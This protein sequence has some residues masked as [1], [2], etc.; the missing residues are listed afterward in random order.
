MNKKTSLLVLLALV[1]LSLYVAGCDSASNPVA[2][3]GSVLTLSANPTFVGLTGSST[4]SITGFRPDGNQLSPGTQVNLAASVGSV[5]PSVV[6]IDDN[7]RAT[8]TYTAINQAG[9]ATIT[10][11]LPGSDTTAEVTVEVG[12]QRPVLE[13]SA[14][15]TTVPVNGRSTIN[16]TARDFNGFTLSN[17]GP[18]V[19]TASNGTVPREVFT[20]S[21]GVATATFRAGDEG[22]EEGVVSAFLRNSE[23]VM[24]SITIRDAASTISLT[25]SRRTIERTE[26]GV[27]VELQALVRNSQGN[28]VGGILVTF[29]SDRGTLSRVSVPTNSSEGSATT[30]LTVTATDVQ[31]IAQNGTFEVSAEVTSE[32]QTLRTVEL[33]QVLGNP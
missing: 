4:I 22:S 16:I 24:V 27:P 3:T 30:T 2:P 33:I 9:P 17:D 26:T 21:S 1:V 19:L 15:P 31:D 32:G 7:G 18:I 29:R 23:T 13:I 14:N 28:P 12:E 8:A 20:D 25:P 5:N 10:G 6:V 11:S